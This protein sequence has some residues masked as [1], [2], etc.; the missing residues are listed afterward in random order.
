M[1]L[2]LLLVAVTVNAS[3]FPMF[4]EAYKSDKFTNPKNKDVVCNFCHMSPSGG[5]DRNPF[6]QAFERGGEVF[7]P[8]L[9][10]QFPDR[11][12]YPMTKV[13]DNLT[14]HFSDPDNK[15]VVV[16]ANGKRVE[17]DASRQTV[18]G[19]PATSANAAASAAPPTAAPPA[20]RP[21][22]AAVAA[23]S[24][25]AP[26]TSD[27]PTD[28]YA[29]EG[30]FFGQNV[31]DLPNGKPQRKGGVDF[32]IGHRFPEATFQSNTSPDLWGFDSSAI[33]TFGVRVGLTN[34]LSVGVA[35]SNYFRTIEFS[36]NYQLSRQGGKSPLTLQA[37]AT[38]EGRNNFIRDTDGV[39]PWV[40]YAPSLQL[41]AVRTFWDRLSLEVVPTFAFN[42][43]N[44]NSVFTQTGVNHNNTIAVGGAA[45]FRFL[46]TASVVGEVVPRVWGY[47]G[48]S[49]HRP[50]IS[51][52]VEKATYRHAFS[53]V[54][55][56]FRPMTVNRY[57]QGTGGSRVG[58]D[59]LGIGFNIYRRIR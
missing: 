50:I 5:D 3:A 42:T 34:R 41:V 51:F 23:S 10:A 2:L 6:G 33:V 24:T 40:G 55:S 27:V 53:L 52:G 49:T 28:P 20:G 11:F 38:V 25:P 4:L 45:G 58:G 46:K 39:I 19:K 30:A 9:R 37:R 1:M 36:G 57:A 8:M 43:R 18:D 29:R 59:A 32:W 15:V 17:V 35:R 14:I 56:D 7:T 21:A 31:V 22:A 54:F 16:E 12:S 47:G 26:Q 48:E 44:E 13:D